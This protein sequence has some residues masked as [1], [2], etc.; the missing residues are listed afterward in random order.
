M[1]RI[2]INAQHGRGNKMV[3]GDLDE[4]DED[5]LGARNQAIVPPWGGW[6]DV[7]T[8]GY[9]DVDQVDYFEGNHEKSFDKDL[10]K[11]RKKKIVKK[12]P[13]EDIFI[14]TISRRFDSGSKGGPTIT[15]RKKND[16]KLRTA[17]FTTTDERSDVTGLLDNA[18]VSIRANSIDGVEIGA[19]FF[20]NQKQ[21]LTCYHVVG[22]VHEKGGS[23][24]IIHNNKAY[25]I[26]LV[27]ADKKRDIAVVQVLTEDEFNYLPVGNSSEVAIGTWVVAVGSPLGYDDVYS[28]GHVMKVYT[29]KSRPYMFI[30]APIQP[31]NSGGPI[32]DLEN[33]NVIGMAAAL[34]NIPSQAKNDIR[35]VGM[36]L[37]ITIDSM[38]PWLKNNNIKFVFQGGDYD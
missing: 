23:M 5:V 28:F 1:S 17:Q 34:I 18:V 30:G 2:N 12:K 11:S 13:K 21:A 10:E 7:E 6:G 4:Y 19:G 33:K 14:P 16:K 37:A 27:A 31:G 29:E 8:T 32:Y 24:N 26:G 22:S 3:P 25:P 9:F 15:K 36:N 35:G 20:I 38:K